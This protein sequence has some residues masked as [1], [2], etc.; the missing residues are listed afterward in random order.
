MVT[1]LIRKEANLTLKDNFGMTSLHPACRRGR[2]KIVLNLLEA[3]A[4]MTIRDTRG[5]TPLNLAVDSGYIEIVELLLEKGAD[6]PVP[7]TDGW[8]SLNSTAI[9]GHVGTVKLLLDRG[10]NVNYSNDTR[11]TALHDAICQGHES[12]IDVLISSGADLT[13]VDIYGRSSLDWMRL[14]G[15]DANRY[16][17]PLTEQR[18]GSDK[19]GNVYL[20]KTIRVIAYRLLNGEKRGACSKFGILGRCFIYLGMFDDAMLALEQQ[21][22]KVDDDGLSSF[23]VCC[24]TC[25]QCPIKGTRW[26]FQ[27]CQDVDLCGDCAGS[28]SEK[29]ITQVCRNHE[30]LC[31][32]VLHQDS[33]AAAT[34]LE[35]LSDWSRLESDRVR[36]PLN[37]V[38]F[39]NQHAV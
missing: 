10:A 26:V 28:R 14:L 3:G 9:N 1:T 33:T 7:N 2:R 16:L 32:P 13:L 18:Q 11:S 39:T 35:R 25:N 19:N 34:I 29:K 6:L 15:L 24:N 21:I 36:N 8:T 12:C 27:V 22:S 17:Q 30:F 5:R 20:A 23:E 31:V 37:V 4:S 38:K